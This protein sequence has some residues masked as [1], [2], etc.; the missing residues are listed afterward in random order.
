[1]GVAN[2]HLLRLAFQPWVRIAAVRM[3]FDARMEFA[4]VTIHCMT[5]VDE[6]DWPFA[7]P[8]NIVAFTTRQVVE[9]G[10]P[11]LTVFHDHQGEW[12][13]LCETPDPV[14]E[15][16]V[17]CMG[18]VVGADPSLQELADLPEGWLAF[19]PSPER[20]WYREEMQPDEVE[21]D[22]TLHR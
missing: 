14:R 17:A 22:S 21:A 10:L 20:E 9:D 8:P 11:V 2:C 7:T 4:D 6:S 5:C 3:P 12:Q 13:F 16:K 18:C 1:M 15:I 19:R